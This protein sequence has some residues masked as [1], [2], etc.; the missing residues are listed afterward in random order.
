MGNR[1]LGLDAVR[2]PPVELA[3]LDLRAA[4][5]MDFQ[6]QET[7]R[8]NPDLSAFSCCSAQNSKDKRYVK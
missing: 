2:H 8:P 5:T 1:I 7:S 4:M 6:V 3:A